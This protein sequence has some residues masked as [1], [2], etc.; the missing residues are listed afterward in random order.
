MFPDMVSD[1]KN[2]IEKTL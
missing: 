2:Q 1:E